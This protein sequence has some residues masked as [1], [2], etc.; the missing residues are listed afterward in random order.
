MFGLESK[1]PKILVIGDLMIDH[2]V[3]GSC[4]RISPEAPVQ[5]VDVKDEN[6]RLGGACN[7]VHNLIALNAQVFVCGVVG[8]DEAGFWLGEK[9]ESMGV[10]I[11]YLFVDTS[12][13][14]TKKTRVIIANQQVLRVDRESKTP[15]DSHIHNNIVQHLHAVLDEVD[16]IIISDYGK[17]LLNDELTHFVIDYAKSKS[18]L[19]LCDPKGKDY[20]KYTGAT[21]LTP[22]KKEAELATGITIC[23]KDSLIKAGMTLKTQC[24]LD[25]SLITLS[26]DG[27]G[28][29]DNNQIH[30]IPTR[31]KEVYDV[32]GAGDTVIAALSFALSSGCDIFQACEFA[33]VAAAVVVGKVGS[34]VATHSEI[35]QYIHTQP[36]NLQQYIESKIISQESL[37]TLLK[38]LKQSK[39]VF[40]NGCFD[41]LHIGHL[42][43]LNKARDLGDILIVGLNDDDSIKRLKGKERPINTLHNRALMLAG[44]ECVDYVVSF[45]QDTPLELIKAIKPDVLV[46]GG[47]Y[48]NKE[49]VGKEYAKEVVLIDFI[50]GH[51]TS[52]IIESIQRSKICKHS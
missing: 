38:D 2:Y 10:D 29:F 23:D 6:N 25:I 15:I 30:I 1:S 43:Y 40:T 36:S 44:L 37:F 3:W 41:I 34:A 26:E 39:I 51:S 4:E 17:G 49:V 21:L 35:L 45:C 8:N 48:H 9:L 31:A 27:I 52:N 19:V 33:N 11:S 14:T 20:S 32:T 42:S 5:V 50:E 13:P 18:K 16:C 24:Q 28:I 47:D 46:K 22:N 7:V 12:R